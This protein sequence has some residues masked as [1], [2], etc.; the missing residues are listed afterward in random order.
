[1]AQFMRLLLYWLVVLV[2]GVRTRSARQWPYPSGAKLF[3][4]NHG[5][6]GD[7]LLL[8]VALPAHERAEVRPVAGADYWLKTP[9][10]RFLALKVFNM[11][12]ID[13]KGDPHQ[14]IEQM[15][16]AL[17]EGSSLILFPE[18][19]RNT[20][21]TLLPFKSGVYHLLKQKPVP[22]VPIWIENIADVLP[23]GR[24]IP[25]P[26]LCALRF[27][28]S[29]QGAHADKTTCLNRLKDALISARGCA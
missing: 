26:M 20:T 24:Y 15:V 5:S 9:M 18:G 2:T 7:F 14:A 3:Y 29:F 17:E 16:V 1:M 27:G 10:R 19:T 28:E 8:W 12:L 6:H 11:V 25:V 23:K 4:A 22:V 13:R 21:E